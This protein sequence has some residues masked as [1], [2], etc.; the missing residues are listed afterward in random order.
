MLRH[1]WLNLWQ[2]HIILAGST[3]YYNCAETLVAP[4]A[5][6]EDATKETLFVFAFLSFSWK[7]DIL[8]KISIKMKFFWISLTSKWHFCHFF[9]VNRF[10]V[11]FVPV[12]HWIGL[13]SLSFLKR[14]LVFLVCVGI[15]WVLSLPPSSISKHLN[16]HLEKKCWTHQELHHALH[17]GR[18]YTHF[19]RGKRLVHSCFAPHPFSQW[20]IMCCKCNTQIPTNVRLWK[21]EVRRKMSLVTRSSH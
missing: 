21:E 9:S 6:P 8:E 10:L 14:M 5:L 4:F 7:T 11:Q 13:V 12:T 2:K 17:R 3:R 20:L 15:Y 1:A 16:N 19:H 18:D